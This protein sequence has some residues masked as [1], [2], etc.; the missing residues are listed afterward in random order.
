MRLIDQA[1]YQI[2]AVGNKNSGCNP[3]AAKKAGNKCG[4]P[5]KKATA[6]SKL[7]REGRQA[8]KDSWIKEINRL[9]ALEDD[10]LDLD[11]GKKKFAWDDKKK[12]FFH[13]ESRS[14]LTGKTYTTFSDNW[15]KHRRQ[16]FVSV[17]RV[18][19]EGDTSS[20]MEARA[21]R[22]PEFKK[23][24]SAIGD[25]TTDSDDIRSAAHEVLTGKEK[26]FG[27]QNDQAEQLLKALAGSEKKHKVWRGTGLPYHISGKEGREALR[28]TLEGMAKRGE[29]IDL[30]LASFS[31]DKQTARN[32]I[33]EE[34]N[35]WKGKIGKKTYKTFDHPVLFN[36]VKGLKG[37][38][39]EA[40][41]GMGESEVISGGRF[42]ILGIKD[43]GG[44]E[45]QVNIEQK[46]VFVKNPR[47][48]VPLL[49]KKTPKGI[50]K[51]AAVKK[52]Q[53]KKQAKTPLSPAFQSKLT[54]EFNNF[55]R[56]DVDPWV[57]KGHG[58]HNAKKIKGWT[59]DKAKSMLK[60]DPVSVLGVFFED[61]VGVSGADD[62]SYDGVPKKHMKKFTFA[63]RLLFRKYGIK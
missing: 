47:P 19:K 53:Y 3:A 6:V 29:T 45:L 22:N 34:S 37:V 54:K 5:P 4:R 21:R 40:I 41:S 9:P 38:P 16:V 17:D 25:W 28:A 30:G 55:A 49:Q 57:E 27:S 56:S 7:I 61:F 26:T 31:A 42:K 39:I 24:M 35:R 12:K 10:V 33:S 58:G 52:A 15:Y 20:V 8:P 2:L 51:R 36:V 32:F 48:I 60:K 23:F 11:E 1:A 13:Y 63:K 18:L 44:G 50:A 59:P 43:I 62:W 46:G 14:P